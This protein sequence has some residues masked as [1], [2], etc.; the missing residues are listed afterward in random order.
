[1]ISEGYKYNQK[2]AIQS[3]LSHDFSSLRTQRPL[4]L[5][6]CFPFSIAVQMGQ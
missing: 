4:R 5:M 2:A 1:M 3:E 6:F